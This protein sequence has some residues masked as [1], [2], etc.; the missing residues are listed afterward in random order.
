MGLWWDKIVEDIRLIDCQGDLQGWVVAIRGY[1]VC[2]LIMSFIK[3]TLGKY[4]LYGY[5]KI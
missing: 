4:I 5:E 3:M 2:Q 1:V